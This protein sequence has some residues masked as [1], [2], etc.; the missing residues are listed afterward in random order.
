MSSLLFTWYVPVAIL[1]V[2]D[3]LVRDTLLDVAGRAARATASG[4]ARL[5][6]DGVVG[7]LRYVRSTRQT[8]E[9]PTDEWLIVQ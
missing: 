7:T 2:R 8:S 3:S 6:Y 4:A 9:V 1:L 5:A